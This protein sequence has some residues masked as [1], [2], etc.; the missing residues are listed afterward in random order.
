MQGNGAM[1]EEDKA[2]AAFNRLVEILSILRGEGGCPWDKEQDETSIAH[3]FL[4]EAYEA[5]DAVFSGDNDHLKEE[6]G[7]VLMEVVFLA[8]I[9]EEKRKFAISDVLEGINDKMVRRHP[10]VFGRRQQDTAV[11]VWEAWNKQKQEEKA[12]MSLLEGIAVSNPALLTAY[13]IGLRASTVGFDWKE[14]GDV[15]L[16]LREEVRELEDAVQEKDGDSIQKE[17]G[18]ILFCLANVSRHL[19]INPEIA[20]HRTNRKFIR[21][22]QALEKQ[23]REK[24]VKLEELGLEEMD[25]MWEEAKKRGA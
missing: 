8:R 3:F 4:E 21:R 2:G 20:L 24:G 10:H 9:S 16:K 1:K 23:A 15:L 5:I 22:F 14:A 18:D 7:D 11:C 25:S 6:L 17:V 12:R 13:Q 19:G